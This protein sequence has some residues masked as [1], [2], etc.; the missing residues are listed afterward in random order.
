MR[1]WIGGLLLLGGTSS[2][3][4]APVAGPLFYED[5]E[6]ILHA[7]CTACHYDGGVGELAM[8]A[9]SAVARAPHI[10]SKVRSRTMPPWPPGPL[11]PP[12]HNARILTDQEIATIGA[13]ADHGAPLGDPAHHVD[14]PPMITFDP[15]RA[16]DVRLLMSGDNVYVP[17]SSSMATDEVRCFVI[18]MPQGGCDITQAPCV[19]ACKT[20]VSISPNGSFDLGLLL[21]CAKH[22]TGP[23]QE[24]LACA[25]ADCTDEIQWCSGTKP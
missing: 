5:V 9:E 3:A 13:W 8:D 22:C 14:R 1:T 12:I 2:P 19:D 10:A 6:P 7:K 15:G 11:G 18:D 4:P 23:W 20:K 21:S 25:E 16:P 17:P 24:W